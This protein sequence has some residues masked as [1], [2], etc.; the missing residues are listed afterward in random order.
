MRPRDPSKPVQRFDMIDLLRGLSVLG[1]VYL[2][3]TN[4]LLQYVH[5]AIPFWLL[6]RFSDRGGA[7]VPCFFV[8]SGFLITLTSIRRFGS[9][10]EVSPSAF[11][12]IRFARIAPPL[13]LLLCILSCLDLA[14]LAPFH[15]E[16]KVATLP[17][18]LFAVIT[19]Q[20]NR[21]LAMY[22]WPPASWVP[23]WTLSVEEMF[24][25]CFPLLCTYVVKRR[26][27]MLA[28]FALLGGFIVL[29]PFARSSFFTTNPMW[30]EHSYLSNMDNIALGC[31]FGL[32]ATRIEGNQLLKNI[33]L[34]RSL[35]VVGVL[36]MVLARGPAFVWF[37][38]VLRLQMI[39][40]KA[41]TDTGLLGLGVCM[42]MLGSVL[43]PSRGSIF[44]TPVRWFGRYCYEVYLNHMFV[45]IGLSLLYTRVPYGSLSLWAVAML[46]LSGLLGYVVCR[47]FSEPMSRLLRGA[48]LPSQLRSQ[49]SA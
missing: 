43:H 46:L 44:T 31:V 45:I 21:L 7:G 13:L 20:F 10:G 35:Q 34:I 4:A 47:Y 27:G 41:S 8:I 16:A 37:Y 11:Y 30:A 38:P 33:L 15:L 1:V 22:G 40:W 5:Q 32:L 24:Y 36:F 23:L 49:A 18:A 48:P 29:G 17:Q 6:P 12:Q 9:L 39:V 25:L 14:N 2:H 26:L 3:I 19:F 42:V 28:F